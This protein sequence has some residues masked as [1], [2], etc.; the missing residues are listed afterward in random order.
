M[1]A[2]V[3]YFSYAGENNVNGNIEI[4]N[5]GFTEIVAEKIAKYM[6]A[7]IFK[8][9]PVNAYSSKYEEVIMRAKDEYENNHEVEFINPKDNLD[10]YDTIF[11]GFPIWWRGYPRIISTFIKKYNGLKNKVVVPF[12]TN[13]EGAFGVS[14]FELNEALKGADLRGGFVVKGKD[15]NNCDKILLEFLNKIR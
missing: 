15:A 13:E 5:K 1:K 11:L 3:V 12:C 2:L 14:E 10:K 7:D 6:N 8:L 9:I 4:I